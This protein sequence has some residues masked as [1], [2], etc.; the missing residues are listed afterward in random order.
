MINAGYQFVIIDCGWA[1]PLRAANKSLSWNP[2]SFPDGPYAIANFLHERQLKFGV[3]ADA[4]ITMCYSAGPGSFRYEQ[5]DANTFASWGVDLLKCKFEHDTS[6][7]QLTYLDEN[8]Y[9]DPASG[10]PELQYSPSVSP[11]W[12]Y[13]A[14]DIALNNTQRDIL[15]QVSD[16]GVDWPAGWNLGNSWRVAQKIGTDFASIYRILNQAV[17]QTDIPGPGRWLDLDILQVGNNVLSLPEEQTHFSLWAILKSPLMIGAVLLDS[18]TT[19]NS[20]SLAILLNKNVI[21]YNQDALGIPA[22]FRRRWTEE[23]Y[24]VWSGPLTGGRTVAAV[25]NLLDQPQQV[26]FD[27][28]D[29]ELQSAGIV[30]DIWN[31]V[32]TANVLTSY[33]ATIQGHGTLLLE[34]QDTTPSGLYG[35]QFALKTG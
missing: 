28:P 31:N 30:K 11:Y 12:H 20:D 35:S 4:G 13:Q 8:C 16:F 29:I 33:G 21:S 27:F 2:H 18:S 34:L 32:T 24:E 23:G 9:S 25:V 22:S 7:V 5:L 17:P 19:I 15:F 3:N 14:M 10:Y 6:R 26:I 1:S